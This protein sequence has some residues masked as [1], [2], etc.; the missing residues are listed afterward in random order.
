[1]TDI[2]RRLLGADIV[3]ATLAEQHYAAAVPAG[4]T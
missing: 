3:R 2:P 4:C 1:M